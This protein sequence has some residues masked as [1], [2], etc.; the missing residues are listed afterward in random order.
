MQLWPAA[1]ATEVLLVDDILL[2]DV[3][4]DVDEDIPGSFRESNAWTSAWQMAA[5]F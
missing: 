4:V 1:G 3:D 2:P 5:E